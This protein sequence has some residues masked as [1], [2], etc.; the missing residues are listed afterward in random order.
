[1]KFKH[2][3]GY[4]LIELLVVIFLITGLTSILVFNGSGA[5][6]AVKV[7]RAT[8]QLEGALKE[9]QALGNS[10]RAFPQ[11][12]ADVEINYDRGYGVY[13]EEGEGEVIIYG[14]KSP[15][16]PDNVLPAEEKYTALNTYETI[17]FEGGVTVQ[18]VN[19]PGNQKPDVSVLFRRGVNGAKIH[20]SGG[21]PHENREWVEITVGVDS[22]TKQIRVNKQGLIEIL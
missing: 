6:K 11:D 21:G 7:D 10:G 1:M 22:T 17:V 8:K 5:R 4:T 16:D 19:F 15:A 18:D 3:Q 9:V 2:V 20:S 12:E 14:G 13:V